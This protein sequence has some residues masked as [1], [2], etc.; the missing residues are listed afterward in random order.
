MRIDIE[1]CAAFIFHE[2]GWRLTS[3]TNDWVA[4]LTVSKTLNILHVNPRAAWGEGAK[5]CYR[6]TF[7]RISPKPDKL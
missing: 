3:N 1:Q 5:S 6:F 2:D 4:A 7:G